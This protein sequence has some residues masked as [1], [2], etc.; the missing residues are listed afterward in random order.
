MAAQRDLVRA[1]EVCDAVGI[2]PAEDALLGLR[3]LGLHRV[4]GGDA[5]ELAEDDGDLSGIDDVVV[6]HGDA[7][8]EIVLVSVLEP[9][10]GFGNLTLAPLGTGRNEADGEGG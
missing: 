4:L 9:V 7:D 10:G 6:V 5:V 2:L 8:L 3:G 1:A